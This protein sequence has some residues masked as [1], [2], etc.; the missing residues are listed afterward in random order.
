M[1]EPGAER[2]NEQ[3]RDKRKLLLLLLPLLLITIS[4]IGVSIWAVFFRDASPPLAPDYAPQTVE[5]NAT[6]IE[7]EKNKD[8]LDAPKGGG[9]V[10]ITYS[11]ELSLGLSE[12][13][14]TLHYANPTRSTQDVVVQIII[15]DT[16]VAQ[17][18]RI[19]PGNQINTLELLPDAD[20]QLSAGGYD[21]KLTAL[22]YNVETGEKAMLNADLPL[23]IEVVE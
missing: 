2:A 7:N 16:V 1:A 3:K 4:A 10:N 5:E 6:P 14:A 17:S 9:A 19:T 11:N 23:K 22:F 20:Q 12:K 13:R 18:G 21:G 8:K 15:K